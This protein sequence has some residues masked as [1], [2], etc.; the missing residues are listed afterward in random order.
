MPQKNKRPP[1]PPAQLPRGLIDRTAVADFILRWGRR[2][3]PATQE[4]E[5]PADESPATQEPRTPT[6][7]HERSHHQA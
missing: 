6:D 1:S 2:P 4:P 7:D 5:A 3:K